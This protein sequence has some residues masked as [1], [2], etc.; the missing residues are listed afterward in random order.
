MI[1]VYGWLSAVTLVFVLLCYELDGLI[2][3]LHH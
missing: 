3:L 1:A 2:S